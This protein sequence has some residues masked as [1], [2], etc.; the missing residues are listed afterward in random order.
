MLSKPA[1]PI[2]KELDIDSRAILQNLVKGKEVFSWDPMARG[3]EEGRGGHRHLHI[4]RMLDIDLISDLYKAASIS[5]AP[6]HP[7]I[8]FRFIYSLLHL[9]TIP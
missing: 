5:S 3:E 2:V 8:F 4:G 6:L 9:I 7:R 1:H